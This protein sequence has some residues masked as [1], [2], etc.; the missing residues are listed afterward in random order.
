MHHFWKLHEFCMCAET[1]QSLQSPYTRAVICLVAPKLVAFAR[2]VLDGATTQELLCCTRLLTATTGKDMFNAPDDFFVRGGL[3]WRNCLTV[4]TD[5]AKS[6]TRQMK[7]FIALVRQVNIDVL[8]THCMAPREFLASKEFSSD[9]GAVMSH[10][11][12]HLNIL[13]LSLQGRPVTLVTAADTIRV[14][15]SKRRAGWAT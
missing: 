7:G 13:N 15:C 3:R 10:V 14:F 11:L 1:H 12:G 2:H 8:F 5:G 9:L 4:Y 6:M